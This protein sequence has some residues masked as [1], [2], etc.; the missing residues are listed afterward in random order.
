VLTLS[1]LP[2]LAQQGSETTVTPQELAK[3]IQELERRQREELLDLQSQIDALEEELEATRRASAPPPPGANAFN[4]QITVFGSFLARID[5]QP[6]YLEDDPAAE[7]IDDSMSLREAEVDLRA[8]ID[9]WADGVLILASEAEVPGEFETGIE[10]GYLTLKKLPLV[11]TAPAGLKLKAGRFRPAFGRFNKI[12]LH[13]LP[14]VDY[15]RSFATFL[16]DEGY[17]QDGVSGQFFLPSISESSTLEGTLEL[18]GGG[19]LPLAEDAR[20]SELAGLA[21]VGWFNELSQAQSLDLGAS[22]W[23]EGSDRTLVGVD[24]TWK[25]K[26][27]ATG[28]WRSLLVGGE[29][30]ASD[31]DDDSSDDALGY[32]GWAQYQFSRNTYLGVRYD[33]AEELEDASLVT[34][35][36]STYLTYYTTEFLRFRLGLDHAESDVEHEDGRNSAFLELTFVFGAHPVEPYWVNR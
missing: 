1:A 15:P 17:I 5:D 14:S 2:A 19:D 13:D 7:R 4:P 23:T 6:V 30:F 36:Y 8:A 20:S 27:H 18:L 35:T 12:H 33:R 25:W 11:D 10:E 34:H 29:L 21:H 24:A 32:F 16:G 31:V 3:Q 22:G 28:Q 9:P 26:P